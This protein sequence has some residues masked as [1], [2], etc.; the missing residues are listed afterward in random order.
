MARK[1]IRFGRRVVNRL[2]IFYSAVFVIAV[3]VILVL[4]MALFG[5][6]LGQAVASPDVWLELAILAGTL[7]YVYKD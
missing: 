1:G 2:A 4:N 6:T 5:D 3:V 7:L